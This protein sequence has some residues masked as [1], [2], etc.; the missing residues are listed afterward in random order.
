MKRNITK[1]LC[2]CMAVDEPL[3]ALLVLVLALPE[4]EIPKH[5][6]LTQYQFIVF[7]NVNCFVS[8]RRRRLDKAAV[9]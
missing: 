4:E 9:A 8:L 1:Q 5:V 3:T 7:K 6:H 2:V